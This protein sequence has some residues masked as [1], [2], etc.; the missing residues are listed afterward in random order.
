MSAILTEHTSR[1]IGRPLNLRGRVLKVMDPYKLVINKGADHGVTM[2]D[3]F[4]IYRLGEE[5]IDPETQEN[6]GRL[7]IVCGEGRP[8][9]IQEKFTTI[10]T[11]MQRVKTPEKKI[12]NTL[13]LSEEVYCQEMDLV[14]FTEPGVDCFFKQI[15]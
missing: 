11:T 8:C 6:L 4:L 12:R 1:L 14:P 15:Q 5:L 10:I 7:E 2:Q 13:F 9:H 3:R